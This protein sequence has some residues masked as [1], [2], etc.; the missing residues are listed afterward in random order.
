MEP[1]PVLDESSLLHLALFDLQIT[2]EPRSAGPLQQLLGAALARQPDSA[3]SG[4]TLRLHA[5]SSLSAPPAEARREIVGRIGLAVLGDTVWF[6]APGCAARIERD[7]GTVHFAAGEEFAA[8]PLKE[9]IDLLAIPLLH[10]LRP[11]GVTALHAS[12]VASPRGAVV[13]AGVSGSGKSTTAGSLDAYGWP[14]IADDMVLLAPPVSP[15][16]APTVAALVLGAACWGDSAARL[17]LASNATAGSKHF[18]AGVGLPGLHRL[19]ALVFPTVLPGPT[20]LQRLPPT[21]ALL[22]LLPAASGIVADNVHA[23]AQM[24]GLKRLLRT[25]PAYRWSLGRDSFGNGALLAAQLEAALA[26]ERAA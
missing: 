2:G 5:V 17:G 16:A 9:R 6:R 13:C 10:L 3:G 23:H 20:S 12:A 8:L 11:R 15:A 19:G 24:Q 26:V 7:A 18:D 21:A 1:E 25:V 14:R 4:R 22:R